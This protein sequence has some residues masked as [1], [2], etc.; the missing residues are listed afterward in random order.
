MR[1]PLW[2]LREISIVESG[3]DEGKSKKAIK[4]VGERQVKNQDCCVRLQ[5]WDSVGV[6][7]CD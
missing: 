1:S 3:K 6:P 4:K 2:N 7:E 5:F